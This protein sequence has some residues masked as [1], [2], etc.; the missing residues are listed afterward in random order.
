MQ[1]INYKFRTI[2]VGNFSTEPRESRFYLVQLRKTRG[3]D[4]SLA[5]T[6]K[7]K[8]KLLSIATS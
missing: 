5:K 7:R 3:T 6:K 8:K 2:V 1:E 4:E